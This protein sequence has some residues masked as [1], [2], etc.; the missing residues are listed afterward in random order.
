MLGYHLLLYALPERVVDH[1]WMMIFPVSGIGLPLVDA[2]FFPGQSICLLPGDKIIPSVPSAR[3]LTIILLPF[4]RQLVQLSPLRLI[5]P[6]SKRVLILVQLFKRIRIFASLIS[7]KLCYSSRRYHI[8]ACASLIASEC[9]IGRRFRDCGWWL[10]CS[11]GFSTQQ[12]RQS[13]SSLVRRF[14][15]NTFCQYR[16]CPVPDR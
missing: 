3:L 13:C 5:T 12:P 15:L 14:Y 6:H 8:M 10:L 2:A 1:Q 16:F 7:G 9:C 11:F 4:T